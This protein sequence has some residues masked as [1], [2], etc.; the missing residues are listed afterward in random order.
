MLLPPYSNTLREAKTTLWYLSNNK[1]QIYERG[2]YLLRRTKHTDVAY[3]INRDVL[4]FD[5]NLPITPVSQGWIG[6]SIVKTN[7]FGLPVEDVDPAGV[8]SSLLYGHNSSKVIAYTINAQASDF[9]FTSFEQG[10]GNN[11]F[12]AFNNKIS[13]NNA[14]TGQYSLK[15]FKS[16]RNIDGAGT[17]IVLSPKKVGNYVATVWCKA[18][19]AQPCITIK[20]VAMATV[21]ATGTGSW[22]LLKVEISITSET[23]LQVELR[24]ASTVPAY[25][26]DLRIYPAN[27]KMTTFTYDHK[28]LKV[29][30]ITGPDNLTS[31][32]EYDGL[33]RLISKRN[34]SGQI[35]SSQSKDIVK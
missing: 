3:D 20:G 27:A 30:S 10:E 24:N 6:N 22:E 19:D 14:K 16:Q 18:G 25:F 21:H 35:I 29:S 8:F 28:L 26:D 31:F 34:N 7:V 13:N 5:S 17:S 23:D 9:N 2:T 4:D 33:G 15:V 1:K 12:T 11:G 32:F